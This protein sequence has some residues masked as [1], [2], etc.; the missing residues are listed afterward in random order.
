MK[1]LRVVLYLCCMFTVPDFNSLSENDKA[2]AVWRGTFL[3]DREANGFLIQLSSLPAFYVENKI[4]EFRAF[5]NKQLSAA[6]L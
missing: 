5:T 1:L 4:T 2:E 3:A 6:Y